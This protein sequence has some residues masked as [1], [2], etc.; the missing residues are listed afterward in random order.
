EQIYEQVIEVDE[1][2]RADGEVLQA[3]DAET[4]RPALQAAF[5]DGI[6]ACAVVLM[7]G[8]RYPEHEQQLAALARDIGFTQV[9]VSHEVSPLMR[10][11]GRG[12]TTVVDA[13]LSPILHRYAN[14]VASEL[15]DTQLM[16]MKSDGGLADARFFDGKDA[17]LSGP[18]GGIVACA[19]T[20]QMAGFDEVIGFDMGGTSTARSHF[21]GEYGRSFGTGIAGVRMRAPRMRIRPVAA[22]G[23]SI[24]HFDG[25]RYRVGPDSAGAAPGP[26]CY[27]R[28]GPLTV[29]DCN[30]MLGKLQ[31]EFFPKVFGPNADEALDT[32][33]VQ[34]KFDALAAEIQQATGDNRS[35]AEV[36]EGF[37]RIAVDNMANAIKQISVQRG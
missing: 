5:D 36:A 28:G 33:V 11:V 17:I 6:R 18:A 4:V 8:Y 24:L 3:L 27:R 37:L 19:R 7:H 12:D 30:V 31:A 34:E 23:G 35:A 9:S 32:A 26:A 1:R 10:M 14:R 21:A 25:S 15:G 13:Y 29:T 16:F 22:G 20:G 2:L